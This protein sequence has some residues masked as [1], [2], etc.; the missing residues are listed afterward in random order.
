MVTPL[1]GRRGPGCGGVRGACLLQS[2]VILCDLQRKQ[3]LFTGVFSKGVLL[4]G[5]SATGGPAG[6]ADRSLAED[7]AT[8]ASALEKHAERSDLEFLFSVLRSFPA[9]V[10]QQTLLG[11]LPELRVS[12]LRPGCPTPARAPCHRRTALQV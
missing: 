10:G 2:C 8:G 4:C 9:H 3:K 12:A 5:T 6:S 1:G 7:A 11:D